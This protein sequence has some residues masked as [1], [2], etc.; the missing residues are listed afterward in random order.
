MHDGVRSGDGRDEMVLGMAAVAYVLV[1]GALLIGASRLVGAA[2][3]A[4]WTWMGTV[5]AL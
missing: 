3:W 4:F 2:W 1:A 5:H